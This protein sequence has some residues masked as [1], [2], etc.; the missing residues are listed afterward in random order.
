MRKRADKG[1]QEGSEKVMEAQKRLG[2][3]FIVLEGNKTGRAASEG[4][5]GGGGERSEA[6]VQWRRRRRR[7]Y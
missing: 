2:Q 7:R 3:P 4:G 1:L 5:A 6:C